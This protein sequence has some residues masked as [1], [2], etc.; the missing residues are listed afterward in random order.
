MS[1]P[2]VGTVATP[3][4]PGREV[5]Q[6]IGPVPRNAILGADVFAGIRDLAARWQEAR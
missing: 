1:S 2:H 4:V 6:T 3:T 5:T